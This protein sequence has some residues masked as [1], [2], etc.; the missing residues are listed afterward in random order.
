[1]ALN[2][3]LK[4]S[5]PPFHLADLLERRAIPVRL[6]LQQAADL[7]NLPL[8]VDNLRLLGRTKPLLLILARDVSV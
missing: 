5:N 4:L 8:K 1:V 7:I 3:A 2:K 6:I